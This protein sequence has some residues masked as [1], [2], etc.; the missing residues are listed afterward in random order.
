[1]CAQLTQLA[2]LSLEGD[3]VCGP[4]GRPAPAAELLGG[5]SALS[6]LTRLTSLT[7]TARA[8]GRQ[9]DGNRAPAMDVLLA[10]P[11]GGL[12]KQVGLWKG[13]LRVGL[14]SDSQISTLIL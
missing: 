12:L 4:D 14:G 11:L 6:R 1:V 5:L 9:D 8:Y 10:L 2:S 7:V 13:G 3:K